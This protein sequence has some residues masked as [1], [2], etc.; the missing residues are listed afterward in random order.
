MHPVL[1]VVRPN[2]TKRPGQVCVGL[3]PGT[4][5][6]DKMPAGTYYVCMLISDVV[7]RLGLRAE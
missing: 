4:D 3:F 6:M 7:C 2:N 5:G 1:G